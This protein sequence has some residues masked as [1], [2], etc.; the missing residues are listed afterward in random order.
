LN[1]DEDNEYINE[2]SSLSSID[3]SNKLNKECQQILSKQ[4]FEL[5]SLPNLDLNQLSLIALH[6]LY[7]QHLT[8]EAKQLYNETVIRALKQEYELINNE[9]NDFIEK[10]NELLELERL[11]STQTIN[12]LIEKY[13]SQLRMN[14]LHLKEENKKL[15]D[16]QFE[17]LGKEYYQLKR[18]FNEITTENELLKDYNAKMYHEKLQE[19]GK[20]F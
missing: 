16:D 1:I 3:V 9:K 17:Q 4:N 10:S 7:N 5:T 14:S 13:E 12:D 19:N 15:L 20:R 18:D 2:I 6:S 11:H 8:D